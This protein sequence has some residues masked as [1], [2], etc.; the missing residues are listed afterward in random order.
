MKKQLAFAVF[1]GLALTVQAQKAT[2]EYHQAQA[3]Q[4]E[5]LVQ[6]FIHPKVAEMDVSPT[7]IEYSVFVT[8]EQVAAMGGN[9][10]D[11]KAYVLAEACKEKSADVIVAAIYFIDSDETKKGY[12]VKVLGYPGTYNKWRDVQTGDYEWI[13]SV[14]GV[15]LSKD[16]QSKDEKSI[17]LNR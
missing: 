12:N 10:S 9:P 7:R 6:T 1:V 14:Y 3:R 13:K 15:D 2:V 11:L 5:P 8:N 4:V 17:R 16:S